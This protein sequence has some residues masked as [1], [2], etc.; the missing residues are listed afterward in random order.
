MRG[1]RDT[2]SIQWTGSASGVRS[3]AAEANNDPHDGVMRSRCLLGA[4]WPLASRAILTG[5]GSSPSKPQPEPL[6]AYYQIKR[7]AALPKTS[8]KKRPGN[9]GVPSFTAAF[10]ESSRDVPTGR[11]ECHKHDELVSRRVRR[12]GSCGL[13]R[14]K[15]RSRAVQGG[16]RPPP[17]ASSPLASRRRGLS[18]LPAPRRRRVD[19]SSQ[20]RAFRIRI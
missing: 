5:D 13:S 19:A 17:V 3:R 4:P 9:R 20:G 7:H 10:L 16:D 15:A 12:S 18:R 2:P 1:A 11:F 6:T 14:R 8:Q